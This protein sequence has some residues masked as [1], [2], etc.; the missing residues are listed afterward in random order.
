MKNEETHFS[1]PQPAGFQ[2]MKKLYWVII[3]AAV[4]VILAVVLVIL[5]GGK[6]PWDLTAGEDNWIKDGRGV[7]VKHGNPSTTPAEVLEQQ[8]LI[9]CVNNLYADWNESEAV[10][11]LQCLGKCL[12]KYAVDFVHV[13]RTAE[14]DLEENQCEI[15]RA[16]LVKSFVELD[17]SGKIVRI[18]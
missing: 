3:I 12:D 5:R 16:G 15:Y 4:V 17:S 1:N 8:K 10:L 9:E 7:Y 2:K 11:N 14:D 13:P 6:S 18:A